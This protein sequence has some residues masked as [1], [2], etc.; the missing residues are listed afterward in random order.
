MCAVPQFEHHKC[1][2]LLVR[3][4]SP[5][6]VWRTMHIRHSVVICPFERSV[7]PQNMMAEWE[8]RREQCISA[9]QQAAIMHA[10]NGQRTGTANGDSQNKFDGVADAVCARAHVERIDRHENARERKGAAETKWKQD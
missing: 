9:T 2:G 7:Q 3:R 1:T 5:V 8:Q 6:S 10:A 4:H